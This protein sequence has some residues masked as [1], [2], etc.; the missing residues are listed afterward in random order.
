VQFIN[1]LWNGFKY[2]IGMDKKITSVVG[3]MEKEE[4]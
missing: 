4:N 3:E 1:P 2:G